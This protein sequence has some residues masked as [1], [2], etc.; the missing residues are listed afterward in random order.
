M[1]TQLTQEESHVRD[2][3]INIAA[4]KDGISYAKLCKD[5]NLP[6]DMSLPYDRTKLGDILDNI[7][8]F[9]FENKRPLL[10]SIVLLAETN[11]QGTGFFKLAARLDSGFANEFKS[12]ML[13]FGIDMMNKTHDYWSKNNLT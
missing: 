5:A 4:K 2:I 9:E 11:M 3:L 10:S 12:N 8:T 13:L 7:S 1:P 6:Y